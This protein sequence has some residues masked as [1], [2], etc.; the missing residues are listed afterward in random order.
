MSENPLSSKVG[1]DVTNYKAGVAELNRQVRVIESGFKAAAAGMEDWDHSANGLELRMKALTGQIGLQQQKVSGLGGV[2]RELAAGG[3]TS[4]R[5]LE[6][7][8]IQINKETESLNKMQVELK[9]TGT[10]LETLGQGAKKTGSATNILANTYT[11]LN[12]ALGVADK[13]IDTVKQVYEQTIGVTLKYADTVRQLSRV[14]GAGAEDTSRLIQMTDDLGL[15]MGDLETATRG[16]AT[17]GIV[18]TTDSL[19]KMS[20]EYLNLAAGTE[21]NT[22][23]L[24]N[25]GRAGLE[26]AQVLEAGSTKIK[27]MSAAVSDNL[28]LTEKQIT[29]ARNLEIAIDNLND[30][31][32]GV[33]TNVSTKVIPILG[34]LFN[35]QQKSLDEEM[36][37]YDHIIGLNTIYW[38]N[39]IKRAQAEREASEANKQSMDAATARWVAM[40]K[41]METTV[42]P[43]D[44]VQKYQW[45]QYAALGKLNPEIN[46]WTDKLREAAE[47]EKE[48]AA[49]T[50]SNNEMLAGI[51]KV[52]DLEERHNEYMIESSAKR[53]ELE[54]ELAALRKQG[55]SET[56]EKIKGVKKDLEDLDGE[57]A[58]N[59]K[60]FDQASYAIVADL[61]TQ[62]LAADGVLSNEDMDKILAYELEHGL[63]SQAAIDDWKAMEA[64][65]LNYQSIYMNM[66][67][68]TINITTNYH[69]NRPG[70]GS[71][72]SGGL[73]DYGYSQGGS[74]TVPS[75]YPNDSFPMNVESGEHVTV[76]PAGKS[77]GWIMPNLNFRG[78]AEMAG[79]STTVNGAGSAAGS[80]SSSVDVG[81]IHITVYGGGNPNAIAQAASDGVGQAL[82]RAGLA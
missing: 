33:V 22:Y 12:N 24:D 4:S 25:F 38:Y 18:L 75:G 31:W 71:G 40:G 58:K 44:N 53:S 37:W 64:E 55:Y 34:D 28:V 47:A 45:E 27:A 6:I 59:Q 32:S 78:L 46:T 7:L 10:A 63:M 41:A 42:K 21:R 13:A 61:L 67:D 65:A 80:N 39:M 81:G 20:D 72:G 19:A 77:P 51:G 43:G 26:M 82:R 76:T 62:Q 79:R 68:K 74:F 9:Q 54:T 17:K 48:V 50:K 60:N 36:Q 11:E 69:N 73:S 30:S 66:P 49:A 2:Y 57:I 56:S 1:L 14:S 8:Q 29:Q 70:T 16:A 5:E 52:F 23:L 35:A 3:K 15:S